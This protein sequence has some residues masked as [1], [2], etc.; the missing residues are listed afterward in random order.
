MKDEKKQKIL[1]I[2]QQLVSIFVVAV[3]TFFIWKYNLF[4]Q[5]FLLCC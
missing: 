4:C 1:A 3:M 2:F 5:Y